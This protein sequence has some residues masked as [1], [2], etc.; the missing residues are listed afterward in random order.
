VDGVDLANASIQSGKSVLE[1][2][3]ATLPAADL[4][5]IGGRASSKTATSFSDQ[6]QGTIADVA[7]YGSALTAT[8]VAADYQAGLAPTVNTNPTS[9]VSSISG[10][11][12][13]LTWPSDHTGW[14][15][16]VQTNSLSEGLGTNWVDVSGSTATDQVTIP[17]NPTNGC[18]F[19]RLVYPPQ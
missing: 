10:N 6:F 1:P 19:Y 9:I 3:G 15:L 12:L 14:Q 5:G 18:V 8:Q 17:M 4:V 13:T 7:I 2:S 11:Q 16:Q